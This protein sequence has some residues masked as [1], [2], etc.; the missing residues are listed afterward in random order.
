MTNILHAIYNFSKNRTCSIQKVY[1]SKN[2][3]QNNGDSLEYYIKDL[4]CDS[5]ECSMSDKNDRY[6]DEFSYLGNSNNPP[7]FII[8][9]GDSFEVKK[10]E[11]NP[12]TIALNSSFPKNKLY[13]D[14][15]LITEQCRCCELTPWTEKSLIYV[16]GNMDKNT[17]EIDTLWFIHGEC[18]AANTK[19][20]INA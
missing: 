18:Y 13:V 10:I 2:K 4:F 1:R 16:I 15:T 14:D 6:S 9:N 17:N 19:I 3:I 8:K 11:G 12:K 7:D 20:Y 5:I